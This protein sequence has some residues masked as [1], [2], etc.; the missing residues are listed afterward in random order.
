MIDK[1]EGGGKKRKKKFFFFLNSER[2]IP[3]PS[4]GGNLL[5]IKISG[6]FLSFCFAGTLWLFVDD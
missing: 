1:R 6:S 3:K 5:F 4:V 2:S